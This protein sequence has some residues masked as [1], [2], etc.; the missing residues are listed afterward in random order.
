L[1]GLFSYE[2]LSKNK[3]A[4]RKTNRYK[5]HRKIKEMSIEES[6]KIKTIRKT[7]IKRQKGGGKGE[8]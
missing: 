1:L 8:K 3:R 7:K 2:K 4:E 6:M 5:D